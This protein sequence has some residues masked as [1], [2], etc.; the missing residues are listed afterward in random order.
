MFYCAKS[1]V[2]DLGGRIKC[3]KRKLVYPFQRMVMVKIQ[4]EFDDGN[5]GTF[6]VEDVDNRPD[7][8]SV[9]INF[10]DDTDEVLEEF[11][12]KSLGSVREITMTNDELKELENEL[13]RSS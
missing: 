12:I 9:V 4:I 6:W 2:V 10:L 5:V 3:L 1:G 8:T 13:N 11:V 7:P